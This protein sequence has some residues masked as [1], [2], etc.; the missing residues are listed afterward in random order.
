VAA[1][2]IA[3]LQ[4]MMIVTGN[5]GFFGILTLILCVPFLDDGVLTR[6]HD[7]GRVALPAVA[8]GRRMPRLVIAV[9]LFFMSLVPFSHA[10]RV[11]SGWLGPVQT[12]YALT[13][14]LP[15]VNPRALRSRYRPARIVVEGLDGRGSA[16]TSSASGRD[17]AR[18]EFMMPHVPPGLAD[19]FAAQA[20]SGQSV[21]L[22]FC[23]AA[24]RGSPD[25]P[26]L[27]AHNPLPILPIPARVFAI[28]TRATDDRGP[29]KPTRG[30]CAG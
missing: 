15:L 12:A 7:A 3:G 13:L 23:P 19:G 22:L 2:A 18:R 30:L 8:P 25:V 11:E 1:A 6:P 16:R 21:V 10:F 9:L 5:Y 26:T 24:V 20:T 27:L 29:V 4:V 14:P 28:H 17:L